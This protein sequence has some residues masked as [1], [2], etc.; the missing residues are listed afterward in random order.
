MV[1]VGRTLMLSRM[2]FSIFVTGIPVATA[3]GSAAS[4]CEGAS[5]EYH[6]RRVKGAGS[7]I[8][9]VV[10]AAEIAIRLHAHVRE[11]ERSIA[12]MTPLNL[13]FG[14]DDR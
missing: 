3:A 1:K 9:R 8:R 12:F 14:G 10:C 6:A 5:E 11:T 7:M 13:E 2:S 4:G